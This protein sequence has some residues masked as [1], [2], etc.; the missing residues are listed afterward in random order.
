MVCTWPELESTWKTIE[1]S[2]TSII[3]T[4]IKRNII[5]LI[6][7]QVRFF[8]LILLRRTECIVRRKLICDLSKMPHRFITC[9]SSSIFFVVVIYVWDCRIIIAHRAHYIHNNIIKMCVCRPVSCFAN[10]WKK[11]LV[12]YIGAFFIAENEQ[13]MKWKRINFKW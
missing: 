1:W 12:S 6:L 4:H 5:P 13:I 9:S 2:W 3:R 10:E 11:K 7:I 8:F